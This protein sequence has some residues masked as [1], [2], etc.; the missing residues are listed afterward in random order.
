[1]SSLKRVTALTLILLLVALVVIFILENNQPAT[2]TFLG[3][4]TP[5]LPFAFYIAMALLLGWVSGPLMSWFVGRGLKR[6]S[7]DSSQ[8]VS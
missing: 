5:Q 8:R 6:R 7:K 4:S 3:W 2:L 1:M